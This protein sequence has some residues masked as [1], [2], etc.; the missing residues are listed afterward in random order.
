MWAARCGIFR[1]DSSTP[2]LTTPYSYF[3]GPNSPLS[4]GGVARLLPF[5]RR[6]MTRITAIPPPERKKRVMDDAK[7]A[8]LDKTEKKKLKAKKAVDKR[9]RH[10]MTFWF[11]P[12]RKCIFCFSWPPL[13][14]SSAGEEHSKVEWI[15]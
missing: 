15:C 3:A 8:R 13:I 4:K 7:N 12:L 10:A 2:L 14:W 11:L 5:F 6:K 9:R 1:G